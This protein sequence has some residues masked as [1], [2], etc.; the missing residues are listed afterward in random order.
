MTSTDHAVLVDL[1]DA[2][3]LAVGKLSLD[4]EWKLP[5]ASD[6]RMLRADCRLGLLVDVSPARAV[7][8]G[9]VTLELVGALDARPGR[10]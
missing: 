7:P 4:C 9:P 6:V 10:A 2:I 1:A 3:S 5:L 8:S